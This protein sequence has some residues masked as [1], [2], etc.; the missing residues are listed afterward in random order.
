MPFRF[1]IVT[2]RNNKEAKSVYT[3]Y[4]K[5]ETIDGE[6]KLLFGIRS[7]NKDFCCFTDSK[8]TAETFARLLNSENVDK[9]HISELIEDYFYT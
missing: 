8:E 6:E 1:I 4:S 9:V 7:G 3:V 2:Y 5:A